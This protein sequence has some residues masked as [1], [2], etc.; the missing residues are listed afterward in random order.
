MKS[1]NRQQDEQMDDWNVQTNLQTDFDMKYHKNK[2][3]VA[4]E[5]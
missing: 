2:T 4:F 1:Q 3:F 5:G